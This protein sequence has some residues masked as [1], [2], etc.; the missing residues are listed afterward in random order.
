MLQLSTQAAS[1]L[2]VQNLIKIVYTDQCLGQNTHTFCHIVDSRV[3]YVC[4]E[5]VVA[6]MSGELT[7]EHDSEL[8]VGFRM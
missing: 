2:Q 6:S 7:T 3:V 8:S 4:V 1:D 5:C